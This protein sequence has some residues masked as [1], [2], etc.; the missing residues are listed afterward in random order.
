MKILK[1]GGTSLATPQRIRTVARL[2]HEALAGGPV[3]VVVS[4]FGGV[5]EEL[6]AAAAAAARHEETYRELCSKLES[7]H[8]EAAWE[9]LNP[10]EGGLVAKI[11]HRFSDL[12]DL[13]HGVY[14]LRE[15]SPRTLDA[16]L[17]YGERLCVDVT[18][19]AFRA[20][21]MAA[22]AHDAR[23]LIV[24]DETF[25][26]AVVDIDASFARIRAAL[27]GLH[28][29]AVVTGFIGATPEGRTTT[30]GRGGSDYTAALLGAALGAA[31]IELWTDV[32]G[33]MSAAPRLVPEAFPQ[34][35]MSYAEL[36]EMSH[37]GAKVVYPPTVH[38]ARSHGIAL[39]IKNTLRPEAP[40]T[41]IEEQVPAGEV[42]VRG[43]SSIHRVA[44][45]RLEGDG[46]V[47]VPGI[48][49]RLFGALARGGVSVILISQASSEHS[50]CFAVAPQ[51]TEGARR[52]V[53]REFEVERRAGVVEELVVEQEQ[54]V[55]AAVG[56]GMREHP[57]I[58]GC[59][60]SVLGGQGINVRAIAQGSS[61]LNVSLVVHRDDEQRALA[62]IHDAFFAPRR[63]RVALAVAGVGRVGGAL[64]EQ[65]RDARGALA[66]HEQLEIRLV[67]LASSRR[68]L[69]DAEGIELDGWRARLDEA[70]PADG[71]EL[72]DFLRR[73]A[74][75]LPVLVD[76]TA[77]G[78]LGGWYGGVLA[79]G[80]AVVAA[81]KLPFA[82]PYD[83]YEN[84]RRAARLGRGG[85]YFEATVGAGLPVLGTLDDLMRTGD[86]VVRVDGVLS[87]TVN[88]VLDRLSAGEP[89]SQ[90]VRGAHAEGLTEPHPFEDLSG[91]DVARKLCILARLAGRRLELADIELEPVIA[92]DDWGEMD[93]PAF[94]QALPRLDDDF[95]RRREKAAAEGRRLRYVASLEGEAARV[96]IEAVAADHP[97]YGLAGPDNLIALT[98]ERYRAS[99]LVI[100]GPGAGPAVTA[101]GVF[102]NVLH[103]AARIGGASP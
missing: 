66:E 88:A 87:G 15:H 59:M 3:V 64:L 69:L 27:G 56:E 86:S 99:P 46:M 1:F 23:Q 75:A 67:A 89:F 70:P 19:A 84:L 30:L 82:G 42:P 10:D 68:M 2:A 58:A 16:I 17:S 52:A 53:S 91:G 40:G 9:L 85:L 81:N 100:R 44:M 79:A 33:V 34:P 31:A 7:R 26:Q 83:L 65:L 35:R 11:R 48:A 47:G 49:M 28:D 50:I 98:T 77:S 76:C 93:L 73:P 61:E 20:A 41:R 14:L 45:M 97:A 95:R 101:A 18:T 103:A 60:F 12:H 74:G 92:G 13:L 39:R 96:A 32:D 36:M 54:S 25:G 51:D 55:I 63:R 29:V 72:V 37:F 78:G 57:G 94:W 21:G 102:A 43:I 62:A 4:A 22:Q 8:G 80:G 24:T 38:P 5:T 90:A 6:L 71:E